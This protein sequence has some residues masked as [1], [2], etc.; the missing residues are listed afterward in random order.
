MIT[1]AEKFLKTL[2]LEEK[3]PNLIVAWGD[4]S[5]YKDTIKELLENKIY[6]DVK[7]E[8][9][10]P[11]V[12]S[13]AID[14]AQLRESINTYPFFSGSNFIVITDPKLL[15]QEKKESEKASEKHKD[16]LKA[17]TEILADIP[18]YS[19]VLCL[20]SKLD[21]RKVF[22]KTLSQIGAIVECDSL[23]YYSLKPWLDGEAAKYGARFDYKATS[24]IMEYMQVTDKVPLLLL[25]GEIAKLSI[26]AGK[27]KIWKAEDVDA[28]FSQ[29]P[30][31]S[32]FALGSAIAS[33]RLDKALELLAV[34]QKKGSANFIPVLARVSF[35]IR[36]L[37]RVKELM[38]KNYS[39][40][41]IVASLRMHPYAAQLTMEACRHFTLKAL[42]TCL[43]ELSNINIKL[44][45]G[46]RQWPRLEEVLVG[47][48][49]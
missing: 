22:Y 46:G 7:K 30:E 25:E 26:Y 19:Y 31:V 3:L 12:F 11:Q 14:L 9:R 17:F 13:Q 35:E 18:E 39:K 43:V 40:D 15:E 37:C 48:L 23:K 21:K 16:D 6:A 41:K 2:K 20:C 32:G 8:E 34:E 38:N 33:R 45:L 28:I 5:Y 44:R 4:E 49:N 27:R 10:A 29:L 24:L 36:R 47:L 42:E 1:T